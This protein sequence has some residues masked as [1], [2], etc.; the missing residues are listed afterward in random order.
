MG[1]YT[2]NRWGHSQDAVRVFIKSL[3]NNNV[4]RHS[5]M[6]L[7]WSARI[8]YDKSRKE[9]LEL[10]TT[11]WRTEDFM[12][13]VTERSTAGMQNQI[14]YLLEYC[15][16]DKNESLFSEKSSEGYAK[17]RKMLKLL[18]AD[19]NVMALPLLHQNEMNMLLRQNFEACN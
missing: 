12:T 18:L 1:R 15:S 2:I 8:C 6:R 11:L 4:S 3:S 5:V 14:R 7:Y 16:I 10:L 13:Q 9:Q 19:S 17:Y